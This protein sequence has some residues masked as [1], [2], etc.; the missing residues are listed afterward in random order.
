MSLFSRNKDNA[1][2]QP[3]DVYRKLGTY[4]ADWVVERIFDYADIPRHVR[5][6][7]RGSGRTM[8]VAASMLMDPEA[9]AKVSG[10]GSPDSR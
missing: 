2:P 3:G 4:G 8:T 5:L 9:F 1:G 10:S 6:I 7:A